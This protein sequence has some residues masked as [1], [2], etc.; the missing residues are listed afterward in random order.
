MIRG[1]TGAIHAHLPFQTS[2]F[3]QMQHNTL[4]GRGTADITETDKTETNHSSPLCASSKGVLLDPVELRRMKL[5]QQ[6]AQ[7]FLPA[8]STAE[9]DALSRTTHLGVGAHP[10]DLEFFG[11]YPILECFEQP[12]FWYCGVVASDGRSSPRAGR[13]A[14]FTDEQMVAVRLK[15][16]QRA[17]V[18]GEYTAVV[19]LMHS[20]TGAVMGGAPRPLVEDLKEIVKATEPLHI[21]THNLADSHPHHLVVALSLV[22]ALRELSYRPKSFCGGEIWRGLDWLTTADKVVFDVSDHQNLSNAL[23]GVYDSQISGG[24]RYDSATAGRKKANATYYDPLTTDRSTALEF[25]MDLMPL[26]DDPELDLRDFVSGL[27]ER[28]RKEVCDRLGALKER[29][30]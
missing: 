28:F 3:D 18:V 10:D 26:L 6:T 1:G 5:S 27:I 13:Y 2:L 7:V 23:M 4:S 8:A 14:G 20:E 11:W 15:E 9:R 12:D 30:V 17:A 24:K 22:T 25:A 16:Q 21:V 29:L 19:H